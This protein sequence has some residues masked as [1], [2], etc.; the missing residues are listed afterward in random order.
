MP[1]VPWQPLD[2]NCLD[3]LD[4]QVYPL[5]I[6]LP[7]EGHCPGCPFRSVAE[8]GSV[9]GEVGHGDIA[10]TELITACPCPLGLPRTLHML[11][12]HGLSLWSI[13]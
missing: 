9:M 12:G 11:R 13:P 6:S 5:Q 2:S 10:S 4:L 7:Q 1:S 3:I 8:L